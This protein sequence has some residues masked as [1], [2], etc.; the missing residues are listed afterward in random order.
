MRIAI[1]GSTGTIGSAL[2]TVLRERGDEVTR[3]VRPATSAEGIAWDPAAG[4]IDAAALEGFDA[5]VNVVGRSI[6]EHRWSAAEKSRLWRSRVDATELLAATLASLRAKPE[7]LVNASAVGYYGD[8]GDAELTEAAPAGS[9]FLADL[10][11]A[12]EGATVPA[13]DAGIGVAKLRNGIVLTPKGGALGRLMAPLG[14]RWISPYRWGLA[15]PVGRGDQWW[16]WISL[17]D[18]M[19]AVLHV[20]DHRI[21]GP[22]NLTTP[23]PVT[24]RRFIAALG[25]VLRRPTV[26]RIPEF[27]VRLVLGSELADA[28]VLQGQRAVPAVLVGSGF[29][30]T[31]TDV[32][33][34]L[35]EAFS[36]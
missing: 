7:M 14:P 3:L 12:W 31:T 11:V 25:R 19:R 32:E 27:A 2:T 20:L 16:S 15:G 1:A 10:C 23:S 29:E 35:R 18:H 26:I 4:T 13:A 28:V 36:P 6:G 34:G 21:T 24:L 33:A 30:F 9:G 5:V 8:G 17:D 22:V